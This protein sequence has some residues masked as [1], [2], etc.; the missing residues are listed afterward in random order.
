MISFVPPYYGWLGNQM[1]QYACVKA[2]SLR[3]GVN[4]SF[5]EK[6]PNLY[7]IFSISA[8]KQF[9][10]DTSDALRLYKEPKFTFTE[11]PLTFKDLVLEGYFQSEKYF[12]DCKDTI[13]K[14]FTFRNQSTYKV[15]PGSCSIHV[16]RGDYLKIQSHHPVCDMSYYNKAMEM[17]KADN[18]L[19][20]SDDPA[21]CS[22]NFKG[23]QFTVVSG[24]PPT[25]D[26]EL[27]SKCDNN[28]I[29]NS[30]FSWWGAWLNIK[31]AHKVIAPKKWFGNGSPYSAK[32]IY[33][34]DWNIL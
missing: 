6:T 34:E 16:R 18:Y 26:M 13:R 2:L 21:W 3:A 20:F 32:D 33:C 4:C 24:N 15:P 1:F 5:P 19:I 7:D 23:D 14:E 9:K 22:D 29:A 11:I 12:S 28:I 30:S 10:Q 8:D 27:M 17:I 31:N 25:E